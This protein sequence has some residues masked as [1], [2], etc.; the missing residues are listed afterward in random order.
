MRQLGTSTWHFALTQGTSTAREYTKQ[1]KGMKANRR[2]ASASAIEQSKAIQIDSVDAQ[3]V[4]K[5]V[6]LSA[7]SVE[8]SED[9][10][11]RERGNGYHSLQPLF[12]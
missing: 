4:P 8:V 6:R 2:Y 7:S 10:V 12:Q 11:S 3:W 5:K 1:S 9:P